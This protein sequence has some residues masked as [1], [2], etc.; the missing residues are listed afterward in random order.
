VGLDSGSDTGSTNLQAALTTGAQLLE[1]QPGSRSQ[2]LF[3]DGRANQGGD[4]ESLTGKARAYPVSAVPLGRPLSGVEGLGLDLPASA[5]PGERVPL[6]WTG[7]TDQDRA[8]TAVL[9]VDGRPVQAQKAALKAGPNTLEFDLDAGVT[10]T[11]SVEVTVAGSRVAG[12]LSVEGRASILVV[13]G[14]GTS[15]ALG[16]ALEAQGFPVVRSPGLPSPTG[17]QGFSAVV[18]D[19]VPAP[20]LGQAA[21]AGLKDWVSAGGGL[22][23]VGGDSSLGR[24]EYFDSALEDMLP[25]R[26][27]SRRRLQFTRSRILFVVDHSGSMTDEVA[28][29]T[30][31]QAAIQG[32]AQS[33]DQLTPQDEVGIL[34][35]DTEATWILPFTPLTQKKTVIA[36]LNAFTQGGGTDMTTAL[37]E[38]LAAFGHPGPVNRHVILLTD[39]QT[40]GDPGFFQ[41]FTEKL[42]AAQVSLTVL[43]IGQDVN[44]S[45]LGS[46]ASGGE[47]IYYH[48][49]GDQVPAVLPKETVRVTRD[50]IQEGRFVPRAVGQNPI[51]NLGTDL[52]AVRGYLVTQAKPGARVLWELERPGGRD[53]LVADGRYGAGRVAVV[54][55]DSGTRWLAGWPGSLYNR[56][57]GQLVRSVETGPRDQGLRMDLTTTA[58]MTHVA[59][60]AVDAGRLR[61]GASLVV[62]KN[63]TTFGLKETAPGHYEASIPAD[64]GLQVMTV[65]DR[66]GPGRTWAWTW[67]PPGSELTRG[68]ADWA[69]LGRLA[70]IPGGKLQP[71][72]SPAP[73]P[74]EWSWSQTD[75]RGWWLL[76]ALGLFL[77]ELGLRSTSLGQ[78]KQAK[79]RFLGWWADQARPWTKPVAPLT[80]RNTGDDEKRTRD[81]YRALATRKRPRDEA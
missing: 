65:Y 69:G 63:G 31:L 3:S 73:P 27:D 9:S 47:G 76:F 67:N 24:G 64:P 15:S 17:Y 71:A 51:Q 62:V 1:G 40:S 26:T 5:R 36:S 32:I 25:V 43:G 13:R 68:G 55:T 79:E 34:E 4:T 41:D 16:Q 53:P 30:K 8:V 42:K 44:D 60:E 56:F 80:I 35:F 66:T 75:L 45:L 39:G 23:V 49:E 61:T 18:L 74:I 72:A 21:L 20:G 52:P 46:L 81:A 77:G 6:R 7:W 58:S 54:T 50:L 14:P 10:G 33:L 12:L 57:W 22:V 70:S 78:L 29:V 28:G 48:V 2:Y 11:R 37:S 59:V 19:N 38:V